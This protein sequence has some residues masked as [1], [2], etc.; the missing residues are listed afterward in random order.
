MF[1]QVFR[2]FSNVNHILFSLTLYIKLQGGLT[3]MNYIVGQ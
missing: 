2:F 3:S 1:T